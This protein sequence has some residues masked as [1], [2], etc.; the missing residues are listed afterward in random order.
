RFE[1]VRDMVGPIERDADGTVGLASPLPP[2]TWGRLAQLVSI[3]DVGSALL[4]PGDEIFLGRERGDIT[5]PEDGYV[6]GSHAVL[7]R[8]GGRYLL[9]DLRSANGT[10]VRLKAKA[11][12]DDGALIRAGQQ[13]FRVET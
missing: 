12:L 4:L 1:L 13:L 2:D 10:H 7:Q 5:F 9:K 8:R 3:D 11:G 6:S